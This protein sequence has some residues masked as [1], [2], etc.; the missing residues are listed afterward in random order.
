[1]RA[2]G[3]RPNNGPPAMELGKYARTLLFFAAT[4]L[5]VVFVLEVF[6]PKPR[7]A[8]VQPYDGYAIDVMQDA[9]TPEKVQA[10][11][12]RLLAFG[13]R[14]LGQPGFYETAA[15][16]RGR[17]EEAGLEVVEQ[18]NRTAIPRTE[19]RDVYVEEGGETRPLE[20][21]EIFPFWPNHM[22]PMVT[23]AEGLSGEL[24]LM[25]DQTLKTRPSFRG[26]IGLIDSREG[27][28]PPPLE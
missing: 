20:D 27:M 1:M 19:R 7:I 5:L 28:A 26:C 23:P 22:Q 8:P 24:V 2:N 13:S 16:I 6:V 11:H 15:Y 9:V 17:F 25:T 3:N 18:D 21:V 12:E 10:E 4:V 14:F